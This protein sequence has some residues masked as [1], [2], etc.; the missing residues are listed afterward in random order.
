MFLL[1][2][3]PEVCISRG[4]PSTIRSVSGAGE[5]DVDCFPSIGGLSATFGATANE[6]GGD[7]EVTNE[8]EGGDADEGD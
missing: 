7:D 6:D 4:G 2:I 3:L 5:L 8:E 1:P